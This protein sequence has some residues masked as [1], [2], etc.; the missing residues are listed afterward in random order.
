VTL[1]LRQ[2]DS[3]M[4]RQRDSVTSRWKVRETM[5]HQNGKTER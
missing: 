5:C 2:C 4:E 1:R 3:K